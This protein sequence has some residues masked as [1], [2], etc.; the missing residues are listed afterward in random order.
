MNAPTRPT[1]EIA[2]LSKEIYERNIGGQVKD[3]L[4]SEVHAIDADAGN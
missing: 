1:A 4:H 2:R 3:A